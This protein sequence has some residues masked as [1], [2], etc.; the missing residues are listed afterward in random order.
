MK[1]QLFQDKRKKKTLSDSSDA[2][3]DYSTKSMSSTLE[4]SDDESEDEDVNKKPYL[5][6]WLLVKFDGK[7]ML[8]DLL[9]KSSTFKKMD[10]K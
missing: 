4:L 2:E 6:D 7:K 10:W 5:N 8:K 3:S 1:N 9:D